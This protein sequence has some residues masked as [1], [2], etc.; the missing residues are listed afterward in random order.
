MA[1]VA[2]SKEIKLI[3]KSINTLFSNF[4]LPV[5]RSEGL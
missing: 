5:I 3:H 4:S 1:N 2:L